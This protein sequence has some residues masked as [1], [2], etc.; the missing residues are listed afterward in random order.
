MTRWISAIAILCL[1]LLTS[2]KL[3]ERKH[4]FSFVPEALGVSNI[5]YANE[6]SWGFGPG[7]NE[8]GVI[9]YELP[10]AVAKEIQRA[11]VGF[12]A[13]MPPKA[14]DSHDWHG[15]YEKWQP[16]PILGDPS[17]ASGELDRKNVTVN[18]PQKIAHY[19][20]KY[21]FGIPID[22]HIEQIVNEA[23]SKPGSFFAYGRIGVLIVIPDMRKVIYVYNG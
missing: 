9:A 15:R 20:D 10:D 8:T 23:I 3:L 11:G 16:T 22:S 14:G 1:V 17:W 18:S 13:A 6:E 19:L 12:F 21:G 5:L 2:F 4:R 7:G